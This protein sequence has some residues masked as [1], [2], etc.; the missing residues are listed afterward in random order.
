MGQ[1]AH[2]HPRQERASVPD[3]RG[4]GPSDRWT[5]APKW[6]TPAFAGRGQPYASPM[7]IL[8]SGVC[9]RCWAHLAYRAQWFLAPKRLQRPLNFG[10]GLDLLRQ[11]VG[12]FR[13]LV[14]RRCVMRRR[15]QI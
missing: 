1:G 6:W 15:V 5:L 10:G 8:P 2:G 14:W 3:V 12:V 7:G 13:G 11:M 9:R 4:H